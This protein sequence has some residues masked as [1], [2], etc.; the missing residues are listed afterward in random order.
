MLH[1][2]QASQCRCGAI[3]TGLCC[4]GQFLRLK[5]RN[6]KIDDVI[7]AFVHAQADA[8]RLILARIYNTTCLGKT[9]FKIVERKY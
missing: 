9:Y 6:A 3:A 2:E 7:I 1:I 8:P 5:A 4:R